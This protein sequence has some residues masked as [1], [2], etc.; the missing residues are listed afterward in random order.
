MLKEKTYYDND[1]PKQNQV[2]LVILEKS[3]SSIIFI[4]G[5]LFLL[6]YVIIQFYNIL[7]V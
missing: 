3:L 7:L 6:A 5:L 2:L 4:I 1:S